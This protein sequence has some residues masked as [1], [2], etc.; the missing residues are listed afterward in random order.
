M[1]DV[2]YLNFLGVWHLEFGVSTVW[3]VAKLDFPRRIGEKRMEEQPYETEAKKETP[4][5]VCEERSARALAGS[6]HHDRSYA[7]FIC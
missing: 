6:K 3:W 2:G 5:V 7:A 4:C 1:F